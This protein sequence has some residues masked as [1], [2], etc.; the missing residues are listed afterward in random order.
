MGGPRKSPLFPSPPLSRSP[1]RPRTR[2]VRAAAPL[3]LLTFL[4]VPCALRSEEHT[5]ELQSQL[6]PVCRL[7]LFKQWGAPGNLHFS[8]PRRSPDPPCAL[9]PAASGPP[10]PFCS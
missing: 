9:A 6:H 3:L 7:F 5:S 10:R 2:R 1:V 8:P 4:G